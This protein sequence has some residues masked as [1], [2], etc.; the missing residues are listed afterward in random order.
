[1]RK[2]KA[3]TK[4]NNRW[5]QQRQSIVKAALSEA[6]ASHASSTSKP[7][8]YAHLLT[9]NTK[10]KAQAARLESIKRR[11]KRREYV[12]RWKEKNGL[13]C[14]G[15]T[16]TNELWDM[17]KSLSTERGVSVNRFINDIVLEYITKPKS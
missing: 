8:Q 16:M 9:P 14:F 10:A 3:T 2:A 12:N 17:V 5:E 15:I 6:S 11:K 1:M 4:P 7:E 13:S